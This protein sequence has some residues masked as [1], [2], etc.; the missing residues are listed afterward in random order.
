MYT[1][2]EELYHSL[3]GYLEGQGYN[4]TE[5]ADELVADLARELVSPGSMPELEHEDPH[6]RWQTYSAQMNERMEKMFNGLASDLSD[7]SVTR[8]TLARA[9]NDRLNALESMYPGQGVWDTE[10]QEELAQR[11][12]P[13]LD[14]MGYKEVS[15]WEW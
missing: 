2:P 7:G 8:L 9:V 13:V 3:V 11:L 1:D 5:K 4:V 14:Q 12:N 6:W 15:R 10:P